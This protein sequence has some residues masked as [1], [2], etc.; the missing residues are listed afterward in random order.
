MYNF[1]TVEDELGV[2]LSDITLILLAAG[3]SSRFDMGVKKQWLRIGHT[4]LWQFV[5][6]KLASSGDFAS[7]IVVGHRDECD[8]MLHFGGYTIVAGGNSRQESLQN[9]LLHVK[10]EFVLVSDVARACVSASLIASVLSHKGRADVVV[11]SIKV[12]DTVTLD[13]A[14]IDRDALRRLQTPQLSRSAILKEALQSDRSFSDESSAI[15]AVGGTRVLIEGDMDAE[16]ITYIEDLQKLPCLKAPSSATFVGNGYDVHAFEEGKAMYLCGVHIPS[17][18]GF[19]A[20]SDGDVAIHA[21]I[22]ALLGAA[23]MGDIGMMFPDSDDAFKGID[24]KELLKRCVTKLHHFGFTINNVDITIIA[25]TPK[26]A[27]YKMQMRHT[28][29]E[30]L[31]LESPRVNVKATTT[32]GLGF[33]GKKE[34]VAVSASASLHYFNWKEL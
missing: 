9:A 21:L 11:P 27:N 20:H 13:G 34:G 29:A 16:K 12:S 6:S 33:V 4:P 26:V 15:V 32:E 30:I 2:F 5:T 31:H 28:L 3:S 14:T 7:V 18:F 23:G 24:S 8:Y 19:K 10:S 22:D 25:Q 17:S 1:V